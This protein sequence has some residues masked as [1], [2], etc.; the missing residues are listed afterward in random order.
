[1]S[2]LLCGLDSYI[3]IKEIPE[4]KLAD[5][6]SYRNFI[7]HCLT[8]YSGYHYEK[9]AADIMFTIAYT[10]IDKEVTLE[11]SKETR[12]ES[13]YKYNRD[14]KMERNSI[15]DWGARIIR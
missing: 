1:M 6:R 14:A 12:L 15:Q 13:C 9:G 2:L 7:N 8:S 4:D 11:T 3:K 5:F 10:L